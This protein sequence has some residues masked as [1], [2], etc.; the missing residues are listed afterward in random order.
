MASLLTS[1]PDVPC[2][3]GLSAVLG[4]EQLDPSCTVADPGGW[5]RIRE[6]VEAVMASAEALDTLRAEYIAIFDR[7]RV[8]NSLYETEYGRG[9][10]VKGNALADIAGFYRAFG[11]EFGHEDSVHEMLDHVS[12][13]LEF[14]ALLLMKQETLAAGGDAEGQAIVCEAQQKFLEAHL[15]RFVGAIATRPGVTAS[16]F[17]GPVLAWCRDLVAAECARL[18]VSPLPVDW[19]STFA[20][21]E[22]MG[23]GGACSFLAGTS[24][25]SRPC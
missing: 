16:A 17:Y 1:Y 6:S 3:H 8:H 14:Y 20:E 12:V 5:R 15:G 23:C 22:E 4:A 18:G 11:L 2:A 24:Q 21:P 7:G 13:E 9:A 10:L 25:P 19:L